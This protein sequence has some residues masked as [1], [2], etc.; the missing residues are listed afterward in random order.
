MANYETNLTGVM[1]QND[2]AGNE[3]RPDWKGSVEI[4]GVHYWCSGWSRQSAKGPL[5]SMKLE[6]KEAQ[7]AQVAKPA[8]AA[9]PAQSATFDDGADIPF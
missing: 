3:K 9:A 2:K 4:D 6:K 1:F 5:I 8:P 7:S